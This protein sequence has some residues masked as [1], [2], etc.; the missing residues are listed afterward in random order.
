MDLKRDQVPVAAATAIASPSLADTV[1]LASRFAANSRA[2]RTKKIYEHCWAD[3]AAWCCEFGFQPLPA[4]PKTVAL[5]LSARATRLKASTLEGRLAAIS[6][7]HRRAGFT[8]DTRDPGFLEV[9][10][11]IRR[12]LGTE[13]KGKAPL[14]IGD[15][16]AIVSTL[17]RTLTG[18]RDRAIFLAGFAGA[19]RRSD[20]VGSNVEDLRVT[21]E[22]ILLR[23]RRGKTDQDGEGQWRAIPKGEIPATCPVRALKEWLVAARLGDGPL[24]RPVDQLGRLGQKRLCINA[25][26]LIVKRAVKRHG[27]AAG[28]TDREIA[29]RVSAVSSHSLRAG[30]ATTASAAGIEETAIM[31]QTGHKRREE[32][33]RYIRLGTTFRGNAASRIGL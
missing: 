16:A 19:L 33:Q 4:S 23:L 6:V 21:S 1:A 7:I 12:T 29:E 17:P 26:T 25:V 14:L 13:T 24:F 15:I 9:W 27:A 8:F 10:R 31:K 2:S 30:F 22:G 5:Y 32:L 20:I 3:F 18:K 11:G 28:W